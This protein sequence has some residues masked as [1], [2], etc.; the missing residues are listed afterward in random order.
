MIY[1]L[2]FLEQLE[3]ERRTTIAERA[4]L[5]SELDSAVRSLSLDRKL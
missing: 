5:Q 4:R 2:R 3:A 1:D